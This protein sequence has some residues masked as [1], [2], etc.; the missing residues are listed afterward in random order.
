MSGYDAGLLDNWGATTGD[1]PLLRKPFS[2]KELCGRVDEVL[3]A[4]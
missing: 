1:A 3:S 4:P 2:V